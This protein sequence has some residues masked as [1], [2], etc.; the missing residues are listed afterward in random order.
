MNDSIQN[1]EAQR[2]AQMLQAQQ[3]QKLMQGMQGMGGMTDADRRNMEMQRDYGAMTP[4]ASNMPAQ[5]GMPIINP[6]EDYG[7]PVTQPQ[8]GGSM[9]VQTPVDANS[10]RGLLQGA[11]S[12]LD[13]RNME[14]GMGR[15][16]AT[17]MNP[18]MM[19]RR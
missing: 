6:Q 18:E 17:M 8:Y 19:R 1:P 13:R 7:M 3:M 2:L 14:Q 12:E 4:M 15:S 16:A 11:I 10:R 9:P 5:G